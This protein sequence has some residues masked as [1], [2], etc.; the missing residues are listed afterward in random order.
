MISAVLLGGLAGA[1]VLPFAKDSYVS[2]IEESGVAV[3]TNLAAFEASYERACSQHAG[4]ESDISKEVSTWEPGSARAADEEIRATTESGHRLLRRMQD[5][6]PESSH[7][8][9][10][11]G[12]T[13]LVDYQDIRYAEQYLMS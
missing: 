9:L 7:P 1:G 3:A 10:W 4:D 8:I 11:Q 6:F 12:L 5:E 13:R 2:I